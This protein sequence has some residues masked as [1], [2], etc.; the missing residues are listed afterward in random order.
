MS[1]EEEEP[2]P[3][4]FTLA[5]GSTLE[6]SENYTG[7]A[8]AGYENG[9][10]YV[11]GFVSGL[12]EGSGVYTWKS[13]ATYSGTY[14][15]NSRSGRGKL[16]Y[17]DGSWFDGIFADGQRS[18]GTVRYA[19]GDA[20]HGGFVGGLRHGEDGVYIFQISKSRLIGSWAHGAIVHGVWKL[21]SGQTWAGDFVLNKPSGPGAWKL[22]HNK[23][24]GVYSVHKAPIDFAPDDL[25]APP[26]QVT[27]I[28]KTNTN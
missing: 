14:V 8:T 12:R 19:N 9:D 28:W 7:Q 24:D 17:P 16:S 23:V 22:Q 27:A 15:C 2:Q 13:G 20:Y 25:N 3:Y 5:D 6:G 26:T 1:T 11:G 4:T 21:H 18:F 10:Q